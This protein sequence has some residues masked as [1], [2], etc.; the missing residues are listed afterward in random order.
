MPTLA[1]E[2]D[3]PSGNDPHRH[4]Q[5]AE[6]FGTDAERYDRARPPYPGALIERIVGRGP[7]PD[8]LDVGTGTG[9][10]ARQFQAAG[11]RVLGVEPD[12]RMADLATR[13]GTETEVATFEDWD[14]GRKT[15]DA[16]VSGTAWHWIDPV[17]GAAKAAQ[18]LRPGG[19]LAPFWHVFQI[20][21]E[22][23]LAV[24]DVCERVMPGSPFDFR[25]LAERPAVDTYQA[26]LAKVVVGIR[27]AGGFG[28]SEQ[29]RY[30]WECTYTREQWLD[31]MPT[32][33]A[34]TRLPPDK[35][36]EVLDGAGAAVDAMGGSF[37]TTHST[38]AVA[39]K[40]T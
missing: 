16:V 23:T 5:V 18:V 25:A 8:L 6:S 28:E 32:Q 29:W 35:L 20:P 7:G 33:G 14:P 9:I 38:L 34:F 13:L 2:P 11:C 19:L 31:Q 40:R 24:A 12:A 39:A 4:R 1:S 21:P 36:Q 15:F 37:T 30:D 26:G 22:I 10:A 17:A 27:E 3:R